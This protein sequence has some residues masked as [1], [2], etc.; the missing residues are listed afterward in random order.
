MSSPPADSVFGPLIAGEKG[1]LLFETW[2]GDPA[3]VPAD[4]EGYYALLAERGIT[5]LTPPK[6][7]RPAS[8]GTRSSE[9]YH[10]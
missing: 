2:A 6:I 1:A 10:G 5:R 7:Q 4:K 3:P 8:A 9:P